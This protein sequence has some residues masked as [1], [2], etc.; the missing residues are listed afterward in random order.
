MGKRGGARVIYFYFVTRE[1]VYLMSVYAKS[2]KGDLSNDDKKRLQKKLG[3]LK[4]E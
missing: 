2:E 4:G 3:E 1:T